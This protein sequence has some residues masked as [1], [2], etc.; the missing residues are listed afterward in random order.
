MLHILIFEIGKKIVF[1]KVFKKF[2]KSFIRQKKFKK[3]DF[4]KSLKSLKS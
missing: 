3:L 4:Q 1:K 2:Q